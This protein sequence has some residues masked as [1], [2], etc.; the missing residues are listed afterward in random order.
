VTSW[1]AFQLLGLEPGVSPAEVQAAYKRLAFQ[2]HPDQGGSAEQF[3][4]LNQAAKAAKA[5]ALTEPC[6][7]CRGKGHLGQ[8]SGWFSTTLLCQTCHGSKLRH[9]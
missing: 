3:E 4:E 1:E 6:P 2:A 7:T 9:L 8:S 5:Y